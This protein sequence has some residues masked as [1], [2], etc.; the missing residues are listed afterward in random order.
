MSLKMSNSLF[1]ASDDILSLKTLYTK[2]SELL[3][4]SK[5]IEKI[6]KQIRKTKLIINENINVSKD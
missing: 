3:E 1:K 2:G 4:K 5:N 6:I